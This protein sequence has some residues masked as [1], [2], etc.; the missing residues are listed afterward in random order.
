MGHSITE[1]KGDDN[2]NCLV[3]IMYPTDSDRGIFFTLWKP[4]SCY[5]PRE[6]IHE[7]AER[8]P[9]PFIL[10]TSLRSEWSESCSG[11]SDCLW[12]HGLYSPWTSSGWNTGVG[13]CSLLQGIFPTQASNPGLL[14]CRW[15]LYQLSH[16]ESPGILEWV[17]YFFSSIS[18]QPRNWTGVFC[19]AGRFF[20]SWASR[21]APSRKVS[22]SI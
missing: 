16:K 11:M 7:V 12:S 14:H 13:S 8:G 3:S 2:L 17:A 5:C 22:G 21:E 6:T 20:T 9:P 19:I 4:R 10:G 15:I 18:S 1:T